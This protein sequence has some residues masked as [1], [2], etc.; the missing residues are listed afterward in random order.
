MSVCEKE[1]VFIDLVG[2]EAS[3]VSLRFIPTCL[4]EEVISKL[5]FGVN[6]A[7]RAEDDQDASAPRFLSW[8]PGLIT[9]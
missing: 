8:P 2:L 9:D 6:D 1:G 3:Q 5:A 4:R 7:G